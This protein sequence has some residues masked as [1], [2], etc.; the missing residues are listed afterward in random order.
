MGLP[1]QVLEKMDE[2]ERAVW[3]GYRSYNDDHP[4]LVIIPGV[5]CLF[6]LFFI[7]Y[8][9][10]LAWPGNIYFYP[11][12][13]RM[14]FQRTEREFFSPHTVYC[15]D[16][17]GERRFKFNITVDDWLNGIRPKSARTDQNRGTFGSMIYSGSDNELAEG[18]LLTK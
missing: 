12:C 10:R 7:P 16:E 9:L 6:L 2:R 8:S 15:L 17:K 5:L 1:K 14:G 11:E 18:N 4:F 3:T 13:K